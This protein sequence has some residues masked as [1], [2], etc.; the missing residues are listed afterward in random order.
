[1]AKVGIVAN[2]MSARDIRRIVSHAG[3][4]P[5][6]DRA[7]IVLRLLTGLYRAGVEEA[8]IMPENGGIRAQVMRVIEREKKT[9]TIA[10]PQ[11]EYLKM[12]VT[13]TADD[14][15]LASQMMLQAGVDAIIVLGGDGTCRVV[16]SHCGNIPIAGISTGTNNAFPEIREPT[17][18]GLG[19]G[20]AVT[21]K[22][23][24]EIAY[25]F[26]KRL[27]VVV[28]E[29]QEIALVDVAIID[30][31]FIGA[32][33]IWQTHQ[34]RDLFTTFGSPDGI[35]MS[36]IVGLLSPVKRS[37]HRGCRVRLLPV[38][39]AENK[40]TVPIAPGLIE[41]VGIASVEDMQPDESYKPCVSNGAIALD[42]E[43]ELTFSATDQVS[44]RLRLDAFRTIDVLS[45]MTYAAKKGLFINSVKSTATYTSTF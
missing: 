4:L 11:I 21:G 18:S 3:N 30:A 13:G 1:M 5:I 14:S 40:L 15:A 45:C 36:S 6:N 42:G 2:P 23:P 8:V 31:G 34:F 7:N 33:A 25:V 10:Y 22:V 20:L 16:V 9:S 29:I 12:P 32:R 35:G 24:S 19:V 17:I 38:P 37:E 27:D 41:E 39:D 43:R 44:I 26:N 28:N